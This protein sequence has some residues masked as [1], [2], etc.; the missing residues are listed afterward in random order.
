MDTALLL[1]LTQI[2][3][4]LVTFIGKLLTFLVDDTYDTTYSKGII[5]CYLIDFVK[6]LFHKSKPFDW[7]I[8]KLVFI[9]ANQF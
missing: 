2:V 6:D 9:L 5:I 3:F 7:V 1:L 4:L 8:E